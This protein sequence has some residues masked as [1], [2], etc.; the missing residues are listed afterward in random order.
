MQGR[1]IKGIAGFY[2]VDTV[3]SG[4]YECRA[5]GIFRKEGKKPLVGDYVRITVLDETKREGSLEEIF[6]RKNELMRPAVANIDQALIFFAMSHPKPNYLLL[7]R[8]LL[9]V[10]RE[11]IPAILC[12]NKTDLV[13]EE[14]IR[15]VKDLY[16]GCGASLHFVSVRTGRG[17]E[18]LHESLKGRVTA[19][20]GP[21][22]AGKSSLTNILQSGVRMETGEISR[23]LARGKNTTRHSELIPAGDHTYILDTPGFTALDT[24]PLEKEELDG[25]Y[26]EFALLRDE[27][28]FS[29]C[30][31]V[32]EPGCRVREAVS[33]GK[34][35]PLRYEGY[36]R[37]YKELLE[38][39]KRQY[40]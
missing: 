21:S 10:A 5:R 32:H 19:L 36:C 35:H 6:P 4:V 16:G 17:I 11:D 34:I 25:Y 40:R 38:A 15:G 24:A 18:A 9:S 12:F 13:T 33:E 20:G 39:E 22:G 2:Y 28:Y 1:I 29:P 31:H 23:K 7:D 8:F 14:E 3:E 27:C 30:S 26:P 37:I